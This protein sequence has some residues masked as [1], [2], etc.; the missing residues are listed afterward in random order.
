[1][2]KEHQK[3]FNLF[4]KCID[5]RSLES[6]KSPLYGFFHLDAGFIAHYNIHGFKDEYCGRNFLR[7][8]DHFVNPP[9]YLFYNTDCE[10]LLQ[11]CCQ[12]AQE[13]VPKIQAEF[14]NKAMNTK[15]K[16]LRQLAKELDCEVIPIG[17]VMAESV[18]EN[19]Q[20]GLFA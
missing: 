19:G 13:Q 17:G 10:E 3:L 4:K 2:N 20:L 15:M 18:E 6:M 16:L 9:Y 7:F 5:E 1:M 8:L 11:N 12:Y 14:D